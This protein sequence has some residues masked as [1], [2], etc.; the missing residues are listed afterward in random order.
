MPRRGENIYRRKDNRWEGRYIKERD[1]DNKPKYGYVYAHSYREVKSK[2]EKAKLTISNTSY[3]PQNV[4]DILFKTI[5]EEWFEYIQPQIK[6]STNIKYYNLLNMYL[7]PALG[8]QPIKQITNAQLEK[9][10]YELL[11]SAGKKNTGLS[12]KTVTDVLSL[13]RNIFK[14]ASQK[15][16]VFLCDANSVKIKQNSKEMHIFSTTEQEKLYQYL[17]SNLNNYNVGILLCLFTG[18]RI[19]E[20]CALRWEDISIQEKTIHIHQTMQRIQSRNENKKT[21]VIIST[22][23]SQCSVRI[24]PL[25]DNLVEIIAQCTVEKNGYF[26]TGSDNKF[27]EPRT[28]Q[29]HFKKVLKENS[30]TDTNFHSLRHTFATRCIELG[31]D[32]KSLSEILGHAS[33]NITMNRYVHPSMKLKRENMQR[34]STLIAVK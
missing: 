24:I 31:F 25:P 23:K 28:M 2:L 16:I 9:L 30:I 10:C 7:L 26:L 6:E 3:P 15:G 21:K 4:Q 12:A 22:P 34:L 29:N 20:V 8:E 5:A 1:N 27:V 11:T 33:V 13:I 32:V 19:G 17:C 18:I 14:F